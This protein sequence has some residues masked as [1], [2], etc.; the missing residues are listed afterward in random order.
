MAGEFR[1]TE[2]FSVEE[3]KWA[4]V[5]VMTRHPK[6]KWSKDQVTTE[7]TILLEQKFPEMATLR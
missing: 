1:L 2:R 3:W 5:T 7:A 4:I 6:A